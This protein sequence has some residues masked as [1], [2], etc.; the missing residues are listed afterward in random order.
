LSI[1]PTVEQ[2]AIIDASRTG[3]MVA[4]SAGA[5]TG[6]TSTLRLIAEANPDKSMLYLAFNKAIQQEADGSFPP[7]VTAKR[8]T[9]S[10]TG[11]SARR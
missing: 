9:R 6:K 1:K 4:I 11:S 3:D 2:L 7:N 8:L 10:H 5:G